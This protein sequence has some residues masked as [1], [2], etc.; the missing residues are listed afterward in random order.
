VCVIEEVLSED[1]KALG[2]SVPDM[3][4]V[5]VIVNPD[6]AAIDGLLAE[7]VESSVH[8]FL[9]I[10]GHR[11]V[12]KAFQRCVK[13]NARMGLMHESRDDQG[14]KGLGRLLLYK[15][16]C[17]RFGKR[18]SFILCM[19][20][21]G[22]HGGRQWYRRCGYADSK[23]LPY[24][25]FVDPP[26]ESQAG[27]ANDAG[28]NDAGLNAQGTV[29][30]MYLGQFILRKGVDILI[31][32][33]GELKDLNWVLN[34][35]GDGPCKSQY[36]ESVQRLGMAERV[37]FLPNM[38]NHLAMELVAESDL[39][40]LP[41][42]FD[43]WGV[44]VNEA[45]LRGVPVV[46]SDRCGALDLLE[47]S[48]RGETFP[49]GSVE[50]LRKV[51][52]RRIAQGKRTPALTRRIREWSRCIEGD[53]AAEYLLAALKYTFEGGPRPVP[54]WLLKASQGSALS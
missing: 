27:T 33:L 2:F 54:P 11:I 10:N 13:T 3:G 6:D 34:V 45:L 19:G 21:N 9:G 30:L 8:V 41:S 35:V 26:D 7:A 37:K 15:W 14:L 22:V 53:V 47:E 17:A 46:C 50:G 20:Y 5:K 43:G 38:A 18:I 52:H 40:V 29:Q 48:W 1:R 44:V 31:E 49:A 25:Y 36:L 24:G 39:F 12:E 4:D 23:I 51:L 32:A 42:R 28:A 16:D